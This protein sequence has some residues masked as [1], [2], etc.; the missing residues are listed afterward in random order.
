M[1]CIHRSA[2]SLW[3]QLPYLHSHEEEPGDSPPGSQKQA[4]L[5]TLR[6]PFRA[7]EVTE[8]S[9]AR[10]SASKKWDTSSPYHLELGKRKGQVPSQ[11]F[12]AVQEHVCLPAAQDCGWGGKSLQ[13]NHWK[14]MSK[15]PEKGKHHLCKRSTRHMRKSSACYICSCVLYKIKICVFWKKVHRQ[16][17]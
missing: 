1:L 4:S 6:G 16:P 13:Q 9:E 14:L 17:N 8:Y 12:P 10:F 11:P 7:S 15:D 2:D 5:V 3:C